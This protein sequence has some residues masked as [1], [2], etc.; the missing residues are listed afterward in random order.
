MITKT[1][2]EI[3]KER[4]REIE[5]KAEQLLEKCEVVT[6]ASINEKGYPRICAVTKLKS[7]GFLEIYFQ[8][9]KRSEYHGKATHFQ[10]NAKASV[11]YFNGGDSVTLVGEVEIISDVEVKKAFEHLCDQRFFKKG[12]ADPRHILLRFRTIEATF[13]IEG[14]FRTCRY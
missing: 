11:C 13:W 2:H 7:N 8:T 12:I 1:A 6:L 5:Q 9:S 4:I 14:K 3:Q 10:N